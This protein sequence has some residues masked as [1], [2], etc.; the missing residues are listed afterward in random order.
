M[1]VDPGAHEGTAYAQNPYILPYILLFFFQLRRVVVELC[2]QLSSA[3][4]YVQ[5]WA[6][7]RTFT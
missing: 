2:Y 5:I 6:R 3:Q 1:S 4:K 7:Q